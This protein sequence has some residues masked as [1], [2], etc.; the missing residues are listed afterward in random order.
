MNTRFVEARQSATG[1]RPEV[2]THERRRG[3]RE[4]ARELREKR[5]ERAGDQVQA[6]GRQ[7]RRDAAQS[8][9]DHPKR[10]W[11]PQRSERPDEPGQ[12]AQLVPCQ[13]LAN[14]PRLP[15]AGLPLDQDERRGRDTVPAIS[16]SSSRRP[17]KTVAESPFAWCFSVTVP[18]NET[19]RIG[20]PASY[21]HGSGS[22]LRRACAEWKRRSMGT[23]G[24][25]ALLFARASR[26]KRSSIAT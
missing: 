23:H 1:E 4:P 2:T 12:A 7:A 22:P 17:T 21:D 16:A 13:E 24:S 20:E 6:G 10:E 25:Y 11:L 19:F 14:E 9:H 3:G 5:A 15:D 8:L 18:D 26:P